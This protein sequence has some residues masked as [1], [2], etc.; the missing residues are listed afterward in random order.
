M[1]T[2]EAALKQAD[3]NPHRAPVVDYLVRR[4]AIHGDT[5][6][7]RDPYS[8]RARE[9]YAIGEALNA[10]GE[11]DEDGWHYMQVACDSVETIYGWRPYWLNTAWDRIGRWMA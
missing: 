9:I 4:I 6:P 1:D 5:N 8:E 3:L 7:E 11:S 2:I 10:L